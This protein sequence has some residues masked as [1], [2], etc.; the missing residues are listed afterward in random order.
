MRRFLLPRSWAAIL[1]SGLTL[2]AVTE[3]GLAQQPPTPAPAP[4]PLPAPLVPP[5]AAPSTTAPLPAD[6]FRTSP[7][8]RT[9]ADRLFRPTPTPVTRSL[10]PLGLSAPN[11]FGDMTAGGCG[12]AAFL[13]GTIKAGFEHPTF[14]CNRANLAENNSPLPRSRVYTRYNHFHNINQVDIFG[15][16]FPDGLN[17]LNIDRFTFGAEIAFLD[18]RVSFEARLPIARQLTSDVLLRDIQGDY[19]LPLDDYRTEILNL[20]FILKSLLVEREAFVL[21]GGLGVNVPTA[22]DFNLHILVEDDE[23]EI[24]VP[25][26]GTVGSIPAYGN[27]YGT[28]QN[29]TVNVSPFLAYLWTPRPRLFTQGFFQVDVPL[30]T[31]GT[32][33]TGTIGQPGPDQVYFPPDEGKLHQQTLLRIN[34]GSG[35]W[36]W[37]RPERSFLSGIAGIL[38]LNYTTA[39][40]DADQNPFTIPVLPLPGPLPDLTADVVVGNLANRIDVL[41]LTSGFHFQLWPRTTLGVGF[42]VPVRQKE[43]DKPF[44]FELNVL[45]NHA[46]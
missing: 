18:D 12:E 35:Y 37:T 42:V 34:V 13:A 25:G 4:N 9:I 10:A 33:V 5:S 31:S 26:I 14:N 1:T 20:Q 6:Y 3:G 19:N 40:N 7:P 39:L 17:Q 21:S 27:V 36:F 32:V 16:T 24:V 15:E 11:M 2:F 45:L 44:D 46:L 23:F 30:N 43:G 8:P 29:S 41:N 28:V 22:Q 38:E